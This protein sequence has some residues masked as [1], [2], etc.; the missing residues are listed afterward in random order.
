MIREWGGPLPGSP[1]S[2]KLPAHELPR[3]PHSC[4]TLSD[5]PP[6]WLVSDLLLLCIAMGGGK[7]PPPCVLGRRSWFPKEGWLGLNRSRGSAFHLPANARP[8]P[9]APGNN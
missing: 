5:N 7:P 2:G 6:W 1:A 4:A 8:P 9:G 3:L